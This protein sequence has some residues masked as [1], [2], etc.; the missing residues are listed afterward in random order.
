MRDVR[1]LLERQARW[2]K[3]RKSLSW[4]EKIRLAEAIRESVLRLRTGGFKP[5]ADE[6]KPSRSTRSGS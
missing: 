1:E 4:P 3:E 2:Q 5:R 6:Q